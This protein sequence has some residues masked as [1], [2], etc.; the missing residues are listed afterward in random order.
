MHITTKQCE[1]DDN[2]TKNRKNRRLVRMRRYLTSQLITKFLSPFHRLHP[3]FRSRAESTT[4]LLTSPPPLSHPPP[5]LPPPAPISSGP[6]LGF[7]TSRPEHSD[8]VFPLPAA[9]SCRQSRWIQLHGGY[10]AHVRS[11][12]DEHE[13]FASAA[14][15]SV[16]R[17]AAHY[18]LTTC[19][20][21]YHVYHE[22]PCAN[23]V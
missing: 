18:T 9:T 4:R 20:I 10:A 14:Q 13:L 19:Y 11:V 8:T 21:R 12:G 17:R 22:A 2:S 16:S 7:V 3:L 15:A 5:P 1:K 6:A 23:Y